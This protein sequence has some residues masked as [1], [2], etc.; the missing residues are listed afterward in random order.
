MWPRSAL[1]FPGSSLPK[2]DFRLLSKQ[3]EVG[4]V[5]ARTKVF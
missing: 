1:H 3:G 5:K 2:N 4:H